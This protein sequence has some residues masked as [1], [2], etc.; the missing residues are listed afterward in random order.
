MRAVFKHLKT[1]ILRGFLAIIPL[2][3][4]Y[5]VLRFL[6]LAVD[7]RVAIIIEKWIGFNVPGLGFVLVL[8]ILYLLGLVASNWAGRGFFGMIERISTRIPLINMIY[9]LGKQIGAAMALPEKQAFKRVV[10]VEQFQPG[11]WSVGFVT[12]HLEDPKSGG[13]LIK[14]FVP[15]GPNPTSGFML[16]VKE[17]Q[18]REIGWSVA[19]A[20]NAVISGGLSGPDQ[21]D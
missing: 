18:V 13:R 9:H 8:V 10:L 3:L 6:Y 21:L 11:V 1:F 5:I 15:Q 12:G 16:I 20:M 2:A 14:L 7:Q 17:S 19:E 4:S